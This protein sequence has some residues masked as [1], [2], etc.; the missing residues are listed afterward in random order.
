MKNS[1]NKPD[2]SLTK[3]KLSFEGLSGDFISSKDLMK[4]LEVYFDSGTYTIFDVKDNISKT[5]EFCEENNFKWDV[6]LWRRVK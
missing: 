1:V 6:S 2:G 3:Q 5:I 4:T